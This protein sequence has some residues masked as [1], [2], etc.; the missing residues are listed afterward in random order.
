MSQPLSHLQYV[1]QSLAQRGTYNYLMREM[2][3]QEMEKKKMMVGERRRKEKRE[4]LKGKSS[5]D[6]LEVIKLVPG[7]G[8][9]GQACLEQRGR[10]KRNERRHFLNCGSRKEDGG[11]NS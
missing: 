11:G 5:K 10:L 2:D 8:D 6:G 4:V 9:D 1:T 3:E 7:M